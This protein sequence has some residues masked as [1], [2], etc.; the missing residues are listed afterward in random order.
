L[1][2]GSLRWHF[3]LI[4]SKQHITLPFCISTC[5]GGCAY[6]HSSSDREHLLRANSRHTSS[7]NQRESLPPKPAVAAGPMTTGIKAGP[8]A[9]GPT[10]A[11]GGPPDAAAAALTSAIVDGCSMQSDAFTCRVVSPLLIYSPGVRSSRGGSAIFR[12]RELATPAR[13]DGR[14]QLV[15]RRMGPISKTNKRTVSVQQQTAVERRV[16]RPRVLLS[17][18]VGSR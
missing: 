11:T 4:E 16:R 6:L 17:Y 15:R 14:T 13:T 9:V 8:P 5:A 2:G 7:V 3:P 10:A 12:R 1:H 18:C